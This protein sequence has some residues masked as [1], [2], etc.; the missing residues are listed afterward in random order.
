MALLVSKLAVRSV[1]IVL[2]TLCGQT[3]CGDASNLQH[4]GHVTMPRGS[5]TVQQDGLPRI[6]DLYNTFPNYDAEG[7]WEQLLGN[8]VLQTT[9]GLLLPMSELVRVYLSLT[10]LRSHQTSAEHSISAG[11][12]LSGQARTTD[13][14]VVA[15]PCHPCMQTG[16]E[17]S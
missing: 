7:R 11:I 14:L 3:L 2:S 10:M 12:D 16:Q 9:A 8:S 17:E 5:F 15:G 6:I 13:E 4:G 1:H